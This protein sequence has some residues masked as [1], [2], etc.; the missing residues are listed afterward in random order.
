MKKD[1]WQDW[2]RR[3]LTRDR[4]E[5][6]SE[7]FYRGVWGRIGT[8]KAAHSIPEPARPLVSIGLACWRAVPIMSALVLL[9]ALYGWF[10]PPDFGQ[11]TTS[12]EPYIMDTDSAPSKSDLLYEIMHFT[13]V[14]E[15]EAEP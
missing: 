8:A 11:V 13:H 2:I 9:I 15:S 12:V 1:H 4:I 7:E 5:P 6:A 10:Y 3:E 14:S